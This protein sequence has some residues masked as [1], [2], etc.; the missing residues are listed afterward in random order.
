MDTVKEF[1]P[2]ARIGSIKQSKVDVENK[3][4]IIASLQL[5]AIRDYELDIF[6]DIDFVIIDEVYHAGA[7]VFCRAFHLRT[8]TSKIRNRS[9]HRNTSN[10]KTEH[11]QSHI[12]DVAEDPN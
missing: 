12:R 2:D 4:I 1:A 10:R 5:L 6:S 9:I 8:R 7:K 11:R 3:D